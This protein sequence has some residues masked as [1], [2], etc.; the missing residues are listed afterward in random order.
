VGVVIMKPFSYGRM[1]HNLIR[2]LQF[3]I[4]HPI[5]VVIPGATSMEQWNLD[6]RAVQ[7]FGDMSSSERERCRDEAW[8]LQ[9]PF[10]TGCRY[11]LPCPSEMNIP[12]LFRMEQYVR[13]FGLSEWLSEER[14]GKLFVNMEG[15][16]DCGI[17]E[18]HC[19]QELPIRER[20]E[21]AHE[22]LDGLDGHRA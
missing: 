21:K 5:A 14:I 16:A 13:T 1:H 4:A 2:A 12:Q 11:C 3:I 8:L 9:E 18:E 22:A 10:C 15:C 6:I 20:L 17:C 7:Q 19:P